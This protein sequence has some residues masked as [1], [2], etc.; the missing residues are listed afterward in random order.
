MT[1][2]GAQNAALSP[3][4][5]IWP[6]KNLGTFLGFVGLVLFL[7]ALGALLLG[8]PYFKSLTEPLPVYKGSTGIRWWIF[9]A[10]TALLGPITLYQLFLYFFNA[11]FFHMEG[12]TT[13]F[14]GWMMVVGL[15]TI[16]ILVGSHFLLGRKEGA[17]GVNYGLMWSEK[18][19]D[20]GKIGKSALLALAV[21]VSGYI[22]LFLVNS[23]LMVDF[24]FWILT[25]KVT[26]YQHFY[27]LLAYIIPAAIYFIPISVVL[28]GTLRPKNGQA[29]LAQEMLINVAILLIGLGI[30]LAYYYI[31]LEFFGA[32]AN[33]GPGGLGLINAI[34]M[35]GLL[36]VIACISTFFY[37]KTGHV[38]IGAF[39]NTFFIVWY[40]V[41]ANAVFSFGG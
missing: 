11:N 20:W 28:H 24:R 4:A 15:I 34:G 6:N 12:I 1:L 22:L 17:T 26:D 40:L 31:P 27:M 41:A 38:Y 5:Q 29:T 36:P 30:V 23:L 10:I 32:P 13:G 33:F 8:T 14:L 25:L 18:G 35:L 9:A 2:Q 39:I 19:I 21:V 37:R 16:A 7:I 3:E